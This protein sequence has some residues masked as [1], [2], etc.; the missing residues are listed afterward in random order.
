[1]T[2]RRI[3][4]AIGLSVAICSA[5]WAVHPPEKKPDLERLEGWKPFTPS[6]LDWLATTLNASGRISYEMDRHF[7]LLYAGVE[8]DDTILIYVRY[9]ADVNR[10]A[11][12]TA[13]ESARKVISIKA[14]SRGWDKWLTVREDI[15]RTD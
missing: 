14:K 7:V 9:T 15:K 13:I 11:M 6:R 10:Y 4:I 1:M 5:V 8:K 3:I 2:T 12:N